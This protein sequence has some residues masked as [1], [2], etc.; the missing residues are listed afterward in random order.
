MTLKFSTPLWTALVTPFNTNNEIDFSS[1]EVLLQRQEK[2]KNGV[3][4]IGSTGEG[5]ALTTQEKKKIVSFA[6]SLNLNIPLMVGVGGFQ[7]E[8]Q[9]H[10][11]EFCE[12]QKIHAYLLLT[13]LYAKPGIEGQF[14]WF[15]SLMDHV[16]KP[17]MLYN[18]PSRSAIKLHHETLQKLSHHPNLWAVKEASG[19]LEEFAKYRLD[20]PHIEIFSGDDGLTPFFASLGAKGLVS[21]ASNAWPLATHRFVECSL[22]GEHQ[23]LFPLWNEVSSALFASSNPVPVKHLLHEQKL[24]PTDLLRAP[25]SSKDL[26][27][28]NDLMNVDKKVRSWL[29]EKFGEEEC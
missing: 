3:V 2:A 1:L 13:P 8:E 17:C 15:K 12:T 21:V 25:L 11:L 23:G 24:I 20:A 22:K 19:S 16:K 9:L 28:R 18:V 7:L 29:K 14:H 4:L 5:L 6:T 26:V 27:S 10:W